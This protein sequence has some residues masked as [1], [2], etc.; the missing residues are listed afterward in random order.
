MSL[1]SPSAQAPS[2]FAQVELGTLVEFRRGLTYKKSD[3]V[4]FS[5]NAVLRANNV[6]PATGQLDLSKI[7]YLSDDLDVPSSRKLAPDSLLICTASGSRTHLGKMAHIADPIDLAFGGFMGLL[8]SRPGLLARYLW[9]FS[10]S[11]AY[12]DFLETLSP[13]ANINNL[14]FDDLASLLL[15]LP[16]LIEQKRIVAML[17]QTF[18][19][20]DRARANAE[21]NLADASTIFDNTMAGVFSGSHFEWKTS[22]LDKVCA[23]ASSLV[24]PRLPQ[25]VNAIHVGAGNIESRTGKLRNLRTSQEERLISGKFPFDESMVLYSKIRPYLE[26]VARPD[27]AGICSADMYP[28]APIEGQITRDFLYWLLLSNTFTDYAIEG[29]AR[30]GMPKVNRDHL[31]QY[32]VELPDVNEQRQIVAKLDAL[33][34]EVTT[35]QAAYERRLADIADLR[36]SMLQ[37]A[38]SGQLA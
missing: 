34:S 23:I 1:S 35:L 3:E 29:S 22:R 20:L 21:T 4:E 7:R 17:D 25:Y 10:R 26:K 37:A 31:F 33:S 36:Q 13:G 28:L 18:A 24:D 19:A 16:P 6:D 30:A 32:E 38:F 15:P 12:R 27:F 8:V 2:L 9:Y 5:S 11:D 14:R